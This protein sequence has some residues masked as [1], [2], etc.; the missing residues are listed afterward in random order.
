MR[1]STSPNSLFHSAGGVSIDVGAAYVFCSHKASSFYV[2]IKIMEYQWVGNKPELPHKRVGIDSVV[3]TELL[4]GLQQAGL[5]ID[6]FRVFESRFGDGGRVWR[7][8]TDFL[9]DG[10]DQLW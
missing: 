2:L 1:C 10:G 8:L 7:D 5:E 4:L 9:Q 3:G 6:P